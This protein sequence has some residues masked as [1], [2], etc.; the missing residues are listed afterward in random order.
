MSTID[1]TKAHIVKRKLLLVNSTSTSDNVTEQRIGNH[2]Y[3]VVS[4]AGSIVGNTTM[5]GIYYPVD[6][7]KKLA[8]SNVGRIPAPV[9]HPKDENGNFVSASDQ[10]AQND[11]GI[12][13][14]SFNY[15]MDGD[16][17]IRDV[18][19]PKE[20]SLNA[21]KHK[22]VIDRIINNQDIDTSTGVCFSP[23]A[24][25]GVGKDGEEYEMVATN[26]SLDHDALLPFEVGASTT[27]MGTG[28]F[29]NSSGDTSEVVEYNASMPAM[30]LPLAPLDTDWDKAEAD[31]LIRDYTESGDE[32]SSTYRRYFL[33]F[34]RD[35]VKEYGAY[36]LPFATVIDGRPHAVLSA[37]NNASSR[38]S[39]TEGLS[40]ADKKR[41]Q[42]VIDMYQAKAERVRSAESNNSQGTFKKA[43]NKIKSLFKG[44]ELSHNEIYSAIYEMLNQGAGDNWHRYPCDIY[45]SYFIY[46]DRNGDGEKHF[47]QGYHV[48]EDDKVEFDGEPYEVERTIE[49][50][51]VTNGDNAMR[52]KI[53]AALNAAEV[54]TD[55][56]DDDALF[57]AYNELMKTQESGSDET[58]KDK[59]KEAVNSTEVP[60]WFK[61]F[62]SQLTAMNS[63][64]EKELEDTAK[65]VAALNAGIDEAA[66][67]AMGLEACKSFLA[68]N[69]GV[70]NA[71]FGQATFGQNSKTEDDFDLT[72]I[73]GDK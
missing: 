14:F 28:L 61:P 24:T 34:D 42:R 53:L 37:I 21:D 29:A 45:S 56:L 33:Y 30:S 5:N 54:K 1:F 18:A 40:E 55:G 3:Y 12:G 38:L 44:N 13:A 19:V 47:K 32:P 15:R 41:A 10:V 35:N 16:R 57:A 65:K 63:S 68:K 71:A 60:D 72:S 2:D 48:T 43:W 67:K 62:A 49:Y 64:A 7:V 27:L 59:K 66:A 70:V 22:V 6:E 17:L 39:Q 4:G 31:K 26:M 51:T 23:L 25:N 20:P 52:E 50:K 46:Y 73:G 8:A 9:S 69:S 58:E 36:K 11:Y